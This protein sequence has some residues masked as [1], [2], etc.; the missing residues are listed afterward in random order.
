MG[1]IPFIPENA[2]FTPEQRAWLNGFLAAWLAVPETGPVSAGPPAASGV[3]LLVLYGSQSGNAEALAKKIGKLARARQYN[4]RVASMESASPADLATEQQVLVVTSTWGEGEMPDNAKAFWHGLSN[5]SSPNL[6]NVRYAVLALGDK[7]YG[8]TFCL[9]GRQFDERLEK[10]GASRIHPRID[11]D[12]D[13]ENPAETWINEVLAKFENA[14]GSPAIEISNGMAEVENVN[15][16]TSIGRKNSFSAPLLANLKLNAEGSAKDVRHI[17]FSLENSGLYYEVGDALGVYPVNCPDFVSEILDT[18][19][20]NGEEEIELENMGRIS[21]HTA[22]LEHLELRPFLSALPSAKTTAA[23]LVEK[24]RPL[25][26]RLYS[27]SSS[28]KAHPGQV[29]LTVGAVR[30]EQEGK[31]RKGACSTFLADRLPVGNS[32][33]VF[34][35]TSHGFRLPADGNIPV[36]MVGPGTGIAPFRAFLEERSATGATGKNWLFF[37]DQK[38]ATDFLYREQLEGHVKS[39]YLHRL[40][41][42]FSRDQADKIYVQD[43]MRER[44]RELWD[45]LQQGAHFYVCGDA[46]RMAKDVDSMLCQIARE[47]GGLSEEN[48]TDFIAVLKK[49][50]RYQRDVY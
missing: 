41:I 6:Q 33:R 28:P 47:Q 5:G 7:N 43:R 18:A 4:A 1:A 36:I 13:F 37:G 39:G 30:F 9:A 42:A 50:K 45:W 24:L 31:S 17:E 19:G 20:L 49:E 23:V 10:L 25:Q 35:Q 48:A 22:L 29:H 16:E 3:S 15:A 2:P 14:A 21:L 27:I 38:S 11:C 26:P 8:D 34:V 12:V 32:A 40:D 44:A 46:K